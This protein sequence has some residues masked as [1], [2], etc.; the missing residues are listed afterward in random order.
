MRSRER[1]KLDVEKCRIDRVGGL[2]VSQLANHSELS[3]WVNQDLLI[4]FSAKAADM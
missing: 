3:V 2:I 1:L 4:V